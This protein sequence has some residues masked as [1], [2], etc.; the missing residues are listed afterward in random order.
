MADSAEKRRARE[1]YIERLARGEPSPSG[2]A[3]IGD[4]IA[5]ALISGDTDVDRVIAKVLARF[6]APP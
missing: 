6:L 2:V 4:V 3:C 1:R 5:S